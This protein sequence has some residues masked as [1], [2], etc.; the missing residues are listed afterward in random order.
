MSTPQ[1]L[2]LGAMALSLPA[3][4]VSVRRAVREKSFLSCVLIVLSGFL[5]AT[6]VSA[7]FHI[8]SFE[9]LVADAKRNL[10]M[11]LDLA[12]LFKILFVAAVGMNVITYLFVRFVTIRRLWI[13]VTGYFF[14]FLLGCLVAG[15]F[16]SRESGMS[17]DNSFFAI[18][19]GSVGVTGMAWGLSY[20]EICMIINV[21]LQACLC[22]TTALWLVWRA[23]ERLMHKR[24]VGN[25]LIMVLAAAYGI[26]NIAG[27]VWVCQHYAMPME[28]AFNLCYHELIYL[29]AK[30]NTTYNNV[31]YYIF[32]VLFVVL[33]VG[34]ILISK[35]IKV[36]KK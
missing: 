24:S 22:L 12:Y 14:L 1:F 19:C 28:E 27:F 32:I 13:F 6:F 34:N 26:A 15:Y 20:K 18:C 7:F 30:Y 35:L 8:D 31:N 16:V 5:T 21:Y 3:L 36:N 17:L 2:I 29:A 9:P 10:E 33:V 23:V 25:I 4:V 11:E